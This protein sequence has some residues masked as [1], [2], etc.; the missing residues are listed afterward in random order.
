MTDTK[1]IRPGDETETDQ[2]QAGGLGSRIPEALRGSTVEKPLD[3]TLWDL[4]QGR[5]GLNDLTPAL[6]GFYTLGHHDGIASCKARIAR[7]E[8]DADRLYVQAFNPAD[9]A[10]L[11]RERMDNASESYWEQFV[12]SG[13]DVK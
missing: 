13:G 4:V 6:A 1:R 9:R 2:K 12:Q 5:I 8:Q 3:A 7:L 10:K 11:I